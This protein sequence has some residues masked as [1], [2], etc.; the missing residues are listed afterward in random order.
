MPYK[1]PIPNGMMTVALIA[2]SIG[3][4]GNA[5]AF[6]RYGGDVDAICADAGN[7]L[8]PEYQPRVEN[9]CT[10]CHND[11]NGGSGAG[12][13]AY[14][15]GTDAI[16][17][18]F[19]PASEPPTTPTCTDSDGDGYFAEGGSCGP[20]DPN[21]NN[22][23][24]YPGAPEICDDKVDNDGNGLVD[25]QD[26]A[27]MTASCTDMDG[28]TYSVEGGNCGA[29]DCDDT[30]A[31]INPGAEESCSDGFDNN[32]NGLVDN[33]DP[34][35]V[36]CPFNCTDLDGDGFSLEGGVCGA[37]DCNDNDISVNPGALEICSDTID[38]NCDGRVD[39]RDASCKSRGRK[40]SNPGKGGKGKKPKSTDSYDV[41]DDYVGHDSDDD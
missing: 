7:A 15:S 21:D 18:L 34:N 35:A 4:S 17:N 16:I 20:M 31:G 37:L 11:G 28:D 3:G 29:V 8:L 25:T 2:I 26:P 1:N 36:N 6:G 13:T 23:T 38:N 39:G 5:Q 9:N 14:L 33:A 32:C 10:A 27:C 30:D 40:D 12:K 22:D 19:C 24:V 41:D